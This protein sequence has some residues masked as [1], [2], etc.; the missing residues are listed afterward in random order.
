MDS[1][2]AAAIYKK[3]P[4]NHVFVLQDKDEAAY[5]QNDLK[6]ILNKKDILFFPDSFK[7]PG[8]FEEINKLHNLLRCR[9][10]PIFSLGF[11]PPE[12]FPDQR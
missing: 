11:R 12:S 5:F 1:L 3:A 2:L 10:K 9:T 6:N 7:K 8:K 4:Q